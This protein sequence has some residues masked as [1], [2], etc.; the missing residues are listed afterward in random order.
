MILPAESPVTSTA[1]AP[2]GGSRSARRFRSTAALRRRSLLIR[3]LAVSALVS[4]CSITATAWVVVNTTAV[5]LGKERGQAL[6]DDA[7]VY[8]TLLGWAATHPDWSG[9]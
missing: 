8:D 9:V 3:L 4:V 6:A 1:A 2:G 7:R 5:V